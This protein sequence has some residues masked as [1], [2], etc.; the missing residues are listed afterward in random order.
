MA[1]EGRMSGP[2]QRGGRSEGMRGSAAQ[3]SLPY[4]LEYQLYYAN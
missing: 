2:P 1:A 4:P 3:A